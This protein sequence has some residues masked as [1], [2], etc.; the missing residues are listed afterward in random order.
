ME[1]VNILPGFRLELLR[2]FRMKTMT[3][4]VF[5]IQ[6]HSKRG[7]LLVQQVYIESSNIRKCDIS[8]SSNLRTYESYFIFSGTRM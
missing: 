8:E 6:F 2:R 3:F 5:C 1:R 7:L 4:T